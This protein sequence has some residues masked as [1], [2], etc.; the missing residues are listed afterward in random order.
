MAIPQSLQAG[1][2]APVIVS[3][4]FIASGVDLVVETRRSG[5]IGTFPSLNARTTEGYED[6]LRRSPH[7][8][9]GRM[10]RP[11][12]STSSSTAPMRG[13]RRTLPRP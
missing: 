10:R 5:L 12:A 6:W 3:P 8:S 2:K 13:W 1:L 4:M 7:A 9:R 11:S